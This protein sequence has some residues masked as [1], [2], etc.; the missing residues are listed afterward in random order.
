MKF[1]SPQRAPTSPQAP[2]GEPAPDSQRVL[3]DKEV[4][5][6]RVIQ[7]I[8]E[9]KHYAGK[10]Q[11]HERVMT[12]MSFVD[13]VVAINW[14]NDMLMHN[15]DLFTVQKFL[16]DYFL[17]IFFYNRFSEYTIYFVVLTVLQIL[18][19]HGTE[20]PTPI[21]KLITDADKREE[22]IRTM[23]RQRNDAFGYNFIGKE[24]LVY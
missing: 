3:Y 7:S 5:V 23:L 1:S 16:L 12:M 2:A 4:V 8:L 18:H 9:H 21:R 11:F 6:S 10:N 20:N 13:G 15:W 22:S 19:D 24:V 14:P 17:K